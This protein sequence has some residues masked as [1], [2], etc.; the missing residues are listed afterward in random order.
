MIKAIVKTTTNQLTCQA[1]IDLP[2]EHFERKVLMVGGS[3]DLKYNGVYYEGDLSGI[4]T[5]NVPFYAQNFSKPGKEI[6]KQKDWEKKL[7]EITKNAPNWDI[8]IICGVPA[9]IQILFQRIIKEYNV[10]NIHDIWP[11][12]KVYVHGGVSF[13]PY[14]KGFEKLLGQPLMYFDTYLASEGFVAFQDRP[15]A[16]GMRMVL[17][18][19]IYYEFVPFNDK[20]FDSDGVMVENPQVLNIGEVKEGEEYALLLSTCSGAWRYLIGDVVKFS[21]LKNYEIIITGRTK[22][23]LSLCGEHLS[24]DN[25][26]KAI[27]LVSKELNIDVKEFTVTG[28]SFEGMFAHHWYVGTDDKVDSKVV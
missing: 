6:S 3:T 23:F 16:E 27:E 15:D 7:E 28:I 24:Q 25:M 13:A 14:K 26:N 2:K 10:N 4:T 18:V 21:N 9:W 1:K 11:N 17:D 20:N 12:L 19:G 8:G 22:H 5:G